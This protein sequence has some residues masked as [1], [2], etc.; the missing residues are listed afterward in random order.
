MINGESVLAVIPARGGSKGVPRKNTRRVHG[1]P[2]IGWTISA[3]RE[4]KYL[5]RVVVSTDDAEIAEM[6]RGLG[7]E[8]PFL[9][10]V[11]LARDDTPGVAPV[12]HAVDAL[13]GFAWV[14]LL[15]PTSP[16]RTA[17]DIDAC[18]ETC[19]RMKAPACVSVSTPAQSPYLMFTLDA[20]GRLAP[21][22]GWKSMPTRRQELPKAYALNGA[23]YVA[24]ADWLRKT[25]TFVAAETAAFVMPA[26]RSLDIDS[27]FDFRI[28]EALLGDQKA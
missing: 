16:L 2:L 15:Q 12:L 7:A 6:A 13:P 27:E 8:V 19:S 18:I 9:R 22:L 3:A 17:G 28:L 11:E 10:P 5:D 1:R 24:R 21:L 14:A 23:I 4:S 26:E 25:R 20:G